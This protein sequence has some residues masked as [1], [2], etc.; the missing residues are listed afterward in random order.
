MERQ[1]HAD[2]LDTPGLCQGND[3]GGCREEQSERRTGASTV[4]TQAP[5]PDAGPR[6]RHSSPAS[7]PYIPHASSSHENDTIKT[8]RTM[9]AAG[10]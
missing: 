3:P 4:A 6:E 8:S 9:K 2:S 7:P 5:G 10:H 1:Y